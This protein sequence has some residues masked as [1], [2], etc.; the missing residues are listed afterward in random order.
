MNNREVTHKMVTIY[1][2]ITLAYDRHGDKLIHIQTH[3]N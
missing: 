3:C 2:I 1:S